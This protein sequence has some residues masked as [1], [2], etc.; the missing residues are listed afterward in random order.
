M[1]EMV[2]EGV[3][4]RVRGPRVRRRCGELGGRV[5]VRVPDARGVRVVE[6]SC[7]AVTEGI[8]TSAIVWG[9]EI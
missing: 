1:E 9:L 7:V 8:W 3:R 4:G 2:V 5:R 6:M